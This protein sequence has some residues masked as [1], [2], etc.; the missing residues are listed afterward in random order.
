MR[1]GASRAGEDGRA[2]VGAPAR[3]STPGT[4][5]P[6]TGKSRRAR[7]TAASVELGEEHALALARVGDHRAV[8]RDDARAAGEA[9]AVVARAGAVA[10]DEEGLVLGGARA[11]EQ[12]QRLGPRARPRRG[13]E[14]ELRPVDGVV[15]VLLGEAQV[16]AD[17]QRRGHAGDGRAHAAVAGGEVERLG[18]RREQV[19]LVVA[20]LLAVRA[21]D[22]Q[23]VD[24]RPVGAALDVAPRHP[25]PRAAAHP[26]MAR[27][28]ASASPSAAAG[29]AACA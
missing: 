5:S 22:A 29:H 8:G 16:E 4:R 25:R 19:R 21:H 7:P 23:P 13:D 10:Q 15:P 14:E 20:R 6:S 24:E 2:P 27:R 1:T 9:R 12:P 3:V 11:G 18:H 28:V 26:G 17:A